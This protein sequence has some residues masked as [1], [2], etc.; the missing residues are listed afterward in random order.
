MTDTE[1]LR[2]I[3]SYHRVAEAAGKLMNSQLQ[4][5]AEL[6]AALRKLRPLVSATG[7]DCDLE[8]LDAALKHKEPAK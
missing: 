3:E 2:K 4:R 1:E 7:A 8:I 6:E 5:I